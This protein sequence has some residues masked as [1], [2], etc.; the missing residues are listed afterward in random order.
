MYLQLHYGI[1]TNR[2]ELR[3]FVTHLVMDAILLE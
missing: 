3:Y 1:L 2:I